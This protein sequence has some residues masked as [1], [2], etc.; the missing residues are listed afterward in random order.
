MVLEN[1]AGLETWLQDTIA[2]SGPRPLVDTSHGV[3]LRRALD[4]EVQP[5]LPA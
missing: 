1:G 5:S 2:N 3:R 4:A